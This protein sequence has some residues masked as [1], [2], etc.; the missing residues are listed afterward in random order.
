VGSSAT[1]IRLSPS[2]AAVCIGQLSYCILS[3]LT[4]TSIFQRAHALKLWKTGNTLIEEFRC[5]PG[6]YV[7]RFNVLALSELNLRAS[8]AHVNY[9]CRY[10]AYIST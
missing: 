9:T 10:V 7:I 6:F 4:S 5:K 2:A 1:L 3:L 8:R